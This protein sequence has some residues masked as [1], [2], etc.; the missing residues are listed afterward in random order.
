MLTLF[1]SLSIPYTWCYVSAILTS[2]RKHGIIRLHPTTPFLACIECRRLLLLPQLTML[3]AQLYVPATTRNQFFGLCKMRCRTLISFSHLQGHHVYR[4]L[5][6]FVMK[7]VAL[8]TS[9]FTR[10]SGQQG[11][12][13]SRICFSKA[14]LGIARIKTGRTPSD[15]RNLTRHLLTP[16]FLSGNPLRT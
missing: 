11:N 16:L 12:L 3:V 2:K 8:L 1:S 4:W 6:P 14:Y 10:R 15:A 9:V 13:W 5:L 7:M